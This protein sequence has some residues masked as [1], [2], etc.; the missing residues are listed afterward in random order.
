MHLTSEG[1]FLFNAFNF[2]SNDDSP[3]YSDRNVESNLVKISKT[4]FFF[5]ELQLCTNLKLDGCMNLGKYS[6]AGGVLNR[7]L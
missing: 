6:G 1:F 7:I 2:L 4:V 5:L 3:Y